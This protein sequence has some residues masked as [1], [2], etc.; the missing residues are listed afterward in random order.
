MRLRRIGGRAVAASFSQPAANEAR[1][2]SPESVARARRL[3]RV[4]EIA[5]VH[6]FAE[7]TCL[8]RSLTL[9]EL[10]RRE[11]IPGTLRVGVRAPGSAFEAHA[12]VQCGDVVLNDRADVDTRYAAFGA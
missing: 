2:L 6:G 7:G 1:A 11:S 12:W 5:S 8:S 10:L 3:Q 9:L 4:V